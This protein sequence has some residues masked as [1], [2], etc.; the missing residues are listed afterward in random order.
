MLKQL[1]QILKMTAEF[2]LLYS[3]FNLTYKFLNRVISFSRFL[4]LFNQK[5][6]IILFPEISKQ[7]F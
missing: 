2:M 3:K 6:N 5:N 4:D 7:F 1:I